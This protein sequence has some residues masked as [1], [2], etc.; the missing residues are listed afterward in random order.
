[1][2]YLIVPIHLIYR[3]E[4]KVSDGR[5]FTLELYMKDKRDCKL[6]FVQEE[7]LNDLVSILEPLLFPVSVM[8]PSLF[9]NTHAEA[10]HDMR[11]KQ[12]DPIAEFTRQGLCQGEQYR[13]F[14]NE[15]YQTCPSY[16]LI[17]IIPVA[18][19]DAHL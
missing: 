13:M 12:W 11:W 6:S 2:R 1:M 18:V 10:V 14:F 8:L 4:K 17:H 15:T 9:L 7:D 16:P 5:S 19:S 3:I